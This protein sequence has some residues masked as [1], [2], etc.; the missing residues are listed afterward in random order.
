LNAGFASKLSAADQASARSLLDRRNNTNL[1]MV[2]DARQAAAL[3]NLADV[4]GG[5][6]MAAEAA[7]ALR[8]VVADVSGEFG[9]ISRFGNVVRTTDQMSGV[10][11]SIQRRKEMAEKPGEH[12]DAL[13]R[14]LQG[15][16]S[17]TLSAAVKAKME[18]MSAGGKA[19]LGRNLEAIE[20]L[21]GKGEGQL[22]VGLDIIKGIYEG[23]TD[24]R[25]QSAEVQAQFRALDPEALKALATGNWSDADF[26]KKAKEE[27]ETRRREN[28]QYVRLDENTVLR[29]TLDLVTNG[30]TLAV[31]SGSRT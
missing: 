3:G 20:K 1:K 9:E 4:L 8:G 21:T 18:A 15:V 17:T 10:E 22:G 2:E 7:A 28:Y 12:L 26:E 30:M 11:K 31:G 13:L 19:V 16:G 24:L 29:G 23:S 6:D 25:S 14:N 27:E 5:D